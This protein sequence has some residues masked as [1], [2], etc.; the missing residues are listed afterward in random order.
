MIRRILL[1]CL[2]IAM[3]LSL[4]RAG[5]SVYSRYGIGDL[6]FF[7]SNRSDAMGGIAIGLSGDGFI[8]RINPA[9]LS[10]ISLTRFSG[11]FE[12]SNFNSDDGLSSGTMS[13]GEFKGLAFAVPISLD[14]GIVLSADAAPFSTVNYAVS[15]TAQQPNQ[16]LFGT[17]GLNS[18]SLGLSYQPFP[19][20]SLGAKA[21]YLY[22]RTRQ[23]LRV[24]F[25]DPTFSDSEVH[26]SR[27][28]SG[29]Q[30][31][32]GALF[33]GLAQI[34]EPFAPLSLGFI[35]N[36][37]TELD[38][39]EDRVVYFSE[40]FDTTNTKRSSI[41]IPLGIGVGISYQFSNRYVI[42]SDLFYQDW[43]KTNFF[44]T[45]AVDLRKRSRFGV[46][47]EVL[48][49]RELT[50]YWSRV[51]FRAGFS[52]HSTYYTINGRG[53]DEIMGTVGAGLPIGPDA[54]LNIGLHYGVR[55][56]TDA[57]L[58]KDTIFRLTLSVSASEAWFI[59]IEE[60]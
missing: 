6:I 9:A 38:A 3:Q 30:F 57:G 52:Y 26:T 42:G 5:G 29:G 17:G 45:P 11:S 54:R 20:L 51:H 7:G 33:T 28:F 58:T 25:L 8:N 10:K 24:N 18:L 34:A 36:I 27:F 44:G 21:S 43:E 39:R 49:P 53:I 14:H 50:G 60:D 59:R 22:G 47:F 15:Y 41:E 37:P 16:T 12:Y 55:G 23:L 32:V 4:S 48:P 19:S 35:L 56:T 46:G 1:A 31:T 2:L 13:R 40:R